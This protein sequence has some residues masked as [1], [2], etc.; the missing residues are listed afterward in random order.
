[1]PSSR[2]STNALIGSEPE[3]RDFHGAGIAPVIHETAKIG[4]YA[5]VDAGMVRATTV[6]PRSWVF[7]HAHLGHDV[8]LGA[9]V[10]VSTGAIVGGGCWVGDNVRIG[11]NA[12]I[13]PRQMIGEG[14]IIG[15]GAVVTRDVP[16]GATVVG[17]PARV[18]TVRGD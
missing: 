12:T 5:T 14:A 1:M 8:I 4:P 9:D 11:L 18:L 13:L 6:G 7:A 2:I 17:N 3:S 16:P 10:E 15:A